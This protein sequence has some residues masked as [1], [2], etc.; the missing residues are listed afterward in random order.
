MDPPAAKRAKVAIPFNVTEVPAT[1][2]AE[3][4][5]GTLFAGK[6]VYF[7]SL[8]DKKN[9]EYE[10]AKMWVRDEGGAVLVTLAH[11]TGHCD[12]TVIPHGFKPD[13]QAPGIL[14]SPNYI[15]F[16][17]SVRFSFAKLA[18]VRL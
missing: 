5:R 9:S 15:I 17:G 4:P 12:F 14:V 18:L 16:C 10:R 2:H 13:A 11:D 8:G 3:A 7:P 1:I 6:V